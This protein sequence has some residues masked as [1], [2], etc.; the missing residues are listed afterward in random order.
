MIVP[1]GMQR[2][3]PL[4]LQV[5]DR[6]FVRSRPVW[7]AIGAHTLCGSPGDI[8]EIKAVAVLREGIAA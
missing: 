8:V 4:F 1:P 7:T 3:L 2:D 6:Y 5:R